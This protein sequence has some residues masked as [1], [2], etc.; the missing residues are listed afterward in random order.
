MSR[1]I[2]KRLLRKAKLSAKKH[3]I[4]GE[5]T[6]LQRKSQKRFI[7]F[8]K[9]KKKFLKNFKNLS[10]EIGE[11]FLT[12]H[13]FKEIEAIFSSKTMS[14]CKI[15]RLSKSFRAFLIEKISTKCANRYR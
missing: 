11:E 4:Q 3:S 6:W 7:K 1:F 13:G 8:S 9:I 5:L 10:D 14:V 12:K 15:Q 2:V